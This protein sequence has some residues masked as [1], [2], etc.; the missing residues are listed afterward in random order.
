VDHFKKASIGASRRGGQRL[1]GTVGKHAWGECSLYLFPGQGKNQV[2]VD[3]ELKDGPSETFGLTLEDTPEGG[4]SFRWEPEA[5]DRAGEMKAKIL[6]AVEGLASP[7]GWVTAKQVAEGAGVSGNTASKW[8][9][10]LADEDGKLERER[11]QV[12]KVKPY[13]YRLRA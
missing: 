10:V 11:R 6:E 4:V 3:T 1:A 12:G 8:L 9:T 5:T 2:R 7:E 13:H